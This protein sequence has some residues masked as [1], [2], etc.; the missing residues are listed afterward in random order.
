MIEYIN[1]L[2]ALKFYI[3]FL[4]NISKE[5]DCIITHFEWASEQD[6][7]GQVIFVGSLSKANWE[8]IHSLKPLY[9]LSCNWLAPHNV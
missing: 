8:A 6:D 9:Y 5:N 1:F 2:M 4:Y 3:V 7:P